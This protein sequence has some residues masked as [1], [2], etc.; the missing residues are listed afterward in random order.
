MP[1]IAIT[2]KK[3][4]PSL[5]ALLKSGVDLK[6]NTNQ[7]NNISKNKL[8]K[9]CLVLILSNIFFFMLFSSNDTNPVH[10]K[11]AGVEVIIEGKLLTSFVEHK[12]VLLTHGLSGQKV[13][14]ILV[15]AQE[16]QNG[17]EG[18]QYLVSSTE[19]DALKILKHPSGWNILPY[20]KNYSL[21]QTRRLNQ[22]I[23]HEIHF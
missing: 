18:A 14:A 17:T 5:L 10:D 8:I 3:I 12:E 1:Y 2:W 22:E 13:K 23:D 4:K 6:K 15:M 7:P 21:H 20:L 19:E 16:S 11:K 9:F